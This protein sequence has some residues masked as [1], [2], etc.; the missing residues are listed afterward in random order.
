M[1]QIIEV[2][3]ITTRVMSQSDLT[4]ECWLIQFEGQAAC[5]DCEVKDT[6]GCGG[7]SIRMTGRNAKG[8]HVPLPECDSA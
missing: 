7:E 6:P 1:T 8:V 4:S 2:G 5:D 3:A